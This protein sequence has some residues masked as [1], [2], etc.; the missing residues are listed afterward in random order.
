MNI[1]FIQDFLMKK[2]IIYNVSWNMVN[3]GWNSGTNLSKQN[4][5][6][7]DFY[8]IQPINWKI[9]ILLQHIMHIMGKK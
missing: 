5:Y 9:I 1:F 6:L 4:L 2:Y 7:S 3:L 8:D